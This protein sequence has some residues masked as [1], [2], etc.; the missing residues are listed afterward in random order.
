[1]TKEIF[2]SQEKLDDIIANDKCIESHKKDKL[3]NNLN[4]TKILRV[5]LPPDT[6]L[7][8]SS[9]PNAK[10]KWDRLRVL[11]SGDDDL[12][13]SIQNTL[14]SEYGIFEQ[15]LDVTIDQNIH[16]FNHF[17]TRILKHATN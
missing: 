11:Y 12:T 7:F 9:V 14:L 15:K 16:H 6:F 17:L 4:A 10:I 5:A 1:M 2:Q 8:V 13:Y 3:I